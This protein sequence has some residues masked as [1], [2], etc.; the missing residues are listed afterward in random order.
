M[1][2]FYFANNPWRNEITDFEFIIII[3]RILYAY[4]HIKLIVISSIISPHSIHYKSLRM[5]MSQLLA[6]A[7]T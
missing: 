6:S 3:I 2:K 7:N 5:I 4:P 1:H